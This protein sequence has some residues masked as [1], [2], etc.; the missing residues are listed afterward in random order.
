MCIAIPNVN[1]IEEKQIQRTA[2]VQE[3]KT[4]NGNE[5]YQQN[6]AMINIRPRIQHKIL[7]NNALKIV[8]AASCPKLEYSSETNSSN[9]NG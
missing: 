4:C 8:S 3:T 5:F 9:N 2:D 1:F 6:A 7:L